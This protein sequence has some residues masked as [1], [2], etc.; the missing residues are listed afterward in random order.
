MANVLIEKN[1]KLE[2]LES[3]NEPDYCT[4]V[5]PNKNVAQQYA[6]PGVLINPD[7][8]LLR[9]VPIKFWK[10]N[11][12]QVIEMTVQEKQTLLDKEEDEK[13]ARRQ[14]LESVEPKLLAKALIKLGI[15][16]KQQLLDSIEEVKNG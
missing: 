11:G 4:E 7:I 3:V 9:N 16:S 1:G 6:K 8:S 12:L 13:E 15:V 2:Y 10:I 5:P 14:E